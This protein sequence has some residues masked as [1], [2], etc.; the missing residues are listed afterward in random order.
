M[1]DIKLMF[2]Y[3]IFKIQTTLTKAFGRP[4]NIEVDESE[5]EKLDEYEDMYQVK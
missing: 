3:I 2:Q 4:E 1:P 5:F